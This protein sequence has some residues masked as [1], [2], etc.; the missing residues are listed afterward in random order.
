MVLDD[1][2]EFERVIVVISID[3]SSKYSQVVMFS[4]ESVA[5]FAVHGI[6]E[7][8]IKKVNMIVIKYFKI[9]FINC[10]LMVS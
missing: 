7:Q 8:I 1:L 10:L 6:M 4:V 5:A 3:P 9:F 2:V